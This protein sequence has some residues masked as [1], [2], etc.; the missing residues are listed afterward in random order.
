MLATAEDDELECFDELQELV[1][2][3]PDGDT[4]W[5]AEWVEED[6]ADELGR[7][8]TAW[9]DEA[10]GGGET[11]AELEDAVETEVGAT[12]GVDD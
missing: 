1:E 3:R 10:F 11:T 7:G 6:T 4:W 8:G 12:A 2:G 5:L 9:E